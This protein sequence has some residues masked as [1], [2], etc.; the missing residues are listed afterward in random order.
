MIIWQKGLPSLGVPV[1]VNFLADSLGLYRLIEGG[2]L[3]LINCQFGNRPPKRMRIYQLGACNLTLESCQD[4]P[5]KC[6]TF[7]IFSPVAIR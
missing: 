2:I 3:L 1:C 7:S 5:F 4:W 6:M